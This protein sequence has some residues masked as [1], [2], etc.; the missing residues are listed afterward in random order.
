MALGA[1]VHVVH[2]RVLPA[3]VLAVEHG[4]AVAPPELA[5]DAPVLEV[6]HPG[7]V[8][9]RPAGRVELDVAR[10]HGLERRALELVDRHEPLLGQP[11]LERSAAAVAVHDGVVELVHVVEQAVLV[12]P[13]HDGL[14]AL[15]AVHAAELAVARNHHGMLVK[16][17]DLLEVVRLAHGVVVGVVRRRDLHEAGAEVGV[18]VPV[19]EDGNLAVDDREPHRLAHELGLLGVGRAHGH[20]RV[21]EHRLGARGGHDDVLH[22]V[23][24][25]GERVAQMPEVAFLVLVLGLVVGDG[26]G[27]VRAPVHDA[28]AA[29]DESVVVPVAEDLAHG[30]G[31][32]RVHGEALVGEVHR[33]AH[34]ANLLDDG[35]AV[36]AAPVPARVDEL[37]AADLEAADALALEL[38]V[39]LGLR[40][41][42]GVVR[43]H[44]PAR[45]AAAH[46]VVADDGVL[47]G[48]VHG[49][50]HVQ[51]ARDVGRRDDDGAVAHALGAPVA[52][53]SDPLVNEPGL[54][55]GGVVGLGHVEPG[56]AGGI[57]LRAGRFVLGG[58]AHEYPSSRWNKLAHEHS[59]RGWRVARFSPGVTEFLGYP[60]GRCR[61]GQGPSDHPESHP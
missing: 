38:L 30:L 4:D 56:R 34:A 13:P 27:A 3:A 58:I 55:L 9:V 61:P 52:A 49:V 42:A 46:A 33:A 14:A 32:G 11:R 21:A 16:D 28:L 31:V 54:G 8:G 29:V 48:I 5:A 57:A 19:G 47:D 40:G 15:V 6:V 41:D 53:G 26:R 18:H 45:G 59:T 36:L 51:H 2:A 37:L 24:G 35:S 25:L 44:D 39:H 43:A 60:V 22:A 1:L 23:D 50:A 7:G 12:E 20:A 10:G 17:V